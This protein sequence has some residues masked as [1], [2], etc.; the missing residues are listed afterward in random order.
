M[1]IYLRYNIK[2]MSVV[3]A[4]PRDWRR[5]IR[6]SAQ[7]LSSHTDDIIYLKLENS[8]VMLAKITSKSL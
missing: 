3:N 7:H 1:Q 8:E 6:Q 2:L 4:I 5:I